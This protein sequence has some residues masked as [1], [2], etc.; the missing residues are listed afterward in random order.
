[1]ALYCNKAPPQSLIH[2]FQGE[3][4]VTMTS[5]SDYSA[6]RQTTVLECPLLPHQCAHMGLQ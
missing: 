4:P 3:M 1:M 5:T 2:S 6:S